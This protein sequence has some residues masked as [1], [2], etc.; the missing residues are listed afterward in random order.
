MNDHLL[1]QARYFLEL[2]AIHVS[3]PLP[4]DWCSIV[5]VL[6]ARLAVV[7][8]QVLRHNE[9]CIEESF[10]ARYFVVLR[11]VDAY[12][13]SEGERESAPYDSHLAVRSQTEPPI[14]ILLHISSG[15]SGSSGYMGSGPSSFA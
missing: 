3:P 1:W 12:K 7:L 11:N 6:L 13:G 10:D 5:L 9:P 15:S 4:P 2:E 14:P 8:L